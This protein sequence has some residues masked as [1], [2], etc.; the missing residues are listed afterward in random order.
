MANH[1]SNGTNIMSQPDSTP[2]SGDSE[3]AM[4]YYGVGIVAAAGLLL[5]AYNIIVIK[6]CVNR[7][8][9]RR[10]DGAP[11]T[12]VMLSRQGRS[13]Q[14]M[15]ARRRVEELVS[16]KYQKDEEAATAASVGSVEC[17]VCLSMF[18]EGEEIKQ[19]PRCKH[20]FHASCIDMWLS[21]HLDCPICRSSI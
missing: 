17:A 4:M 7:S 1:E 8:T 15:A 12:L 3:F 2:E 16:F 21:S 10:V 6:C 18:E 19:L 14:E 5:L 9:R 20:S 13:N 11:T